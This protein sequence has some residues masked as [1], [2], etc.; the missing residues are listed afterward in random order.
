M[1]LTS[2]KDCVAASKFS[3]TVT[4]LEDGPAVNATGVPAQGDVGNAEA[5]AACTGL[6]GMVT[7]ADPVQPAVVLVTEKVVVASGVTVSG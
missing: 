5:V 6:T 4:A 3:V 7:E 2:V 1:P